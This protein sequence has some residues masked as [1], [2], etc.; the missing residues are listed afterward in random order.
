[1][2]SALG[3]PTNVSSEATPNLLNSCEWLQTQIRTYASKLFD[4]LEHWEL[5][6]AELRDLYTG[7]GRLYESTRNSVLFRR[8]CESYTP[9]LKVFCF[10]HATDSS[11][12][13]ESIS[14][15][16]SNAYDHNFHPSN[17]SDFDDLAS[18]ITSPCDSFFLARLLPHLLQSTL[19]QESSARL[20]R[21]KHGSSNLTRPVATLLRERV[22]SVQLDGSVLNGTFGRSKSSSKPAICLS[23]PQKHP[24]IY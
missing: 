11:W 16:N 24:R 12:T 14:T 5:N 9:S 18:N 23:N 20:V 6:R 17:A 22:K 2:A 1:M 13:V 15:D 10:L 3:A 8:H 21:D 4:N 19:C 7:F